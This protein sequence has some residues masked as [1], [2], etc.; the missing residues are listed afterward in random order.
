[1]R[2]ASSRD[3]LGPEGAT[4]PHRLPGRGRCG[5]AVALGDFAGDLELTA[6]ACAGSLRRQG[7]IQQ[8][9]EN[10]KNPS[11]NPCARRLGLPGWFTALRTAVISEECPAC[12]GPSETSS[13]PRP[14]NPPHAPAAV[15]TADPPVRVETLVKAFTFTRS[16][17]D[18]AGS[19]EP[20]TKHRASALSRSPAYV[21]WR[22]QDTCEER[23]VSPRRGSTAVTPLHERTKTLM[24]R[25]AHPTPPQLHTRGVRTD[26]LAPPR[27]VPR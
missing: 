23:R 27:R 16:A 7:V 14:T 9:P 5:P 13:S 26:G 21:W 18:R 3:V 22:R 19:G 25:Q 4:S 15:G 2:C 6:V 17:H 11:A 8:T 1:M 10:A 24:L 20:G 12:A